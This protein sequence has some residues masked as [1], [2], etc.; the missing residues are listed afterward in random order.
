MDDISVN[1]IDDETK[2]RLIQVYKKNQLSLSEIKCYVKSEI[3]RVYNG[4]LTKLEDE[5]MT[6][7]DGSIF[8]HDY[9]QNL[10]QDK[11]YRIFSYLKQ[12]G[13]VETC[14]SGYVMFSGKIYLT[15][16]EN[17]MV[18]KVLFLLNQN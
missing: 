16:E 2:K 13:Y 15:E 5:D 6:Y 17:L 11:D 3:Q 1:I 18:E 7:D 12:K 10:I 8:Y 9:I 4:L 14:G